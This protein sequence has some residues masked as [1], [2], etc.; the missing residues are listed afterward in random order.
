MYKIFFLHL[1][2]T[3]LSYPSRT[4]LGYSTLRHFLNLIFKNYSM[5]RYFLKLFQLKLF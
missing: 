3:I 4:I 5:L 2:F 1:S